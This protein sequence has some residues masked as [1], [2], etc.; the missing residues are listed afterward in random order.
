[1]VEN[2]AGQY[3]D[4]SGDLLAP[5]QAFSPDEITVT[6]LGG[7]AAVSYDLGRALSAA[8]GYDLVGEDSRGENIGDRHTT[9][10]DEQRPVHLGQVSAIGRLGPG[11]EYAVD[12]HGWRSSGEASWV[13]TTSA[14]VGGDPLAGRGKL[15]ERDEEGSTLRARARWSQGPFEIGGG[16]GTAYRQVEITAPDPLDATSFN[17]FLTTVY[18]RQNADSIMLP[19][20]VRSTVTEDRRWEAGGGLAWKRLPWRA[21]AGAEFHAWRDLHQTSEGQRGP[22]ATGWEVRSGIE[23]PLGEVV[24]VRGGYIYRSSDE[25]DDTRA[26]EYVTHAVTLG[27]GLGPP[28]AS[29]SVETGLVADWVQADFGDPGQPRTGR[30]ILATQLRWAF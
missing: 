6:R 15:L 4:G 8:V 13:F 21:V 22:K 19:D 1:V 30:Q 29:W 20:S 28:G 24:R 3:I 27:L 5:P 7:G 10:Q 16:L 14:G 26:N 25:D 17:R 9:L 23:L 12:A 2:A 18:Y 11:L